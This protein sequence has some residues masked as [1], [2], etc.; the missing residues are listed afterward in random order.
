MVASG[1]ENIP[2]LVIIGQR[3][4][5]CEDVTTRLDNDA[6]LKPYITEL[7]ECDDKM[8][9]QYLRG[10]KA[11]IFPSFA[12]G[13]G[14]P[15]MEA[16]MIGTPV[17]ASD[18]RVFREI[19]GDVPE[20]LEPS[21]QDSWLD[22]IQVYGADQSPEREKQLGRMTKLKLPSWRDHFIKI[23]AWLSSLPV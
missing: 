8:L 15:L 20:F 13:Y 3:G 2:Q 12:E 1:M 23:D 6:A 9:A 22:L 11:L 21:D 4:W 10:A 14:M 5:Q 18:I 19:A 7:S 17:I 16:L